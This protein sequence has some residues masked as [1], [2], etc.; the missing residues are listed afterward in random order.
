MKFLIKLICIVTV[1]LFSIEA[2]AGK[3]VR[4]SDIP[5]SERLETMRAE[6][7]KQR[8]EQRQAEADRI[9]DEVIEL[10]T[11]EQ[12]P[13]ESAV[14][15]S[16]SLEQIGRFKSEA[17]DA[18]LAAANLMKSHGYTEHADAMSALQVLF[19]HLFV[20][21]TIEYSKGEFHYTPEK[22]GEHFAFSIANPFIIGG[23]NI[24]G[25]WISD[26]GIMVVSSDIESTEA[27]LPLLVVHELVHTMFTLGGIPSSDFPPFLGEDQD[28]VATQIESY[29]INAMTGGAYEREIQALADSVRNKERSV[30]IVDGF[31]FTPMSSSLDRLFR[32]L[33]MENSQFSK[34]MFVS[35]AIFDLNILLQTE[36]GSLD[37]KDLEWFYHHVLV[38]GGYGGIELAMEVYD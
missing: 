31:V 16:E 27:Y 12:V 10:D 33:G 30:H 11:V 5:L 6:N 28:V 29:F 24:A 14:R 15:I 32:D 18:M 13:D 36:S 9:A 19:K 38:S 8:E 2:T 34:C 3:K 35:R 37:H 23:S 25:M 7:E 26:V 20:P 4:E 1:L 17:E 21:A 22:E